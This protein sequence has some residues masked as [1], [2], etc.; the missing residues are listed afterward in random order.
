MSKTQVADVAYVFAIIVCLHLGQVTWSL[1]LFFGTRK[2]C[3]HWGHL[4][5]LCV[6]L[7]LNIL[8]LMLKKFFTG[9]ISKLNLMFSLCLFCILREKH[10]K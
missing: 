2:Y 9:L 8:F 3:L 4:K 1:P 5:Y 10:R 6:F 7:S